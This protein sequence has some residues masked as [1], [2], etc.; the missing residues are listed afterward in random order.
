[1]IDAVI[2]FAMFAALD[3]CIVGF[4]ARGRISEF[5]ARTLCNASNELS[6][7]LKLEVVPCLAL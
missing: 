2:N 4:S 7:R 3:L 1:M 6:Q 5:R